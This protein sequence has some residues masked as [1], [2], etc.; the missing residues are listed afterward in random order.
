[1]C[2]NLKKK[3]K[4]T[5]LHFKLGLKQLRAPRAC[6][7]LL[8]TALGIMIPPE[9]DTTAVYSMHH[10]VSWKILDGYYIPVFGEAT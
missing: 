9:R 1:M 6:S 10:C 5:F 8:A 3:K 4:K 2:I 7:L